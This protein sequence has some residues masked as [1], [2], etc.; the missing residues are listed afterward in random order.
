MNN[1]SARPEIQSILVYVGGDL[2]GDALMKLPF[3][4]ALRSSFPD[5]Q[6]TWCAGKHKSAFAKE[7]KTIVTGLIDEVIE[8]AGFDNARQFLWRRP[9]DGR[10][11]DLVIDTQRGVAVSF[12]V[13]RIRHK[14]FVSGAAKFLLSDRKPEPGYQRPAS[15]V[16]QMT[17]L[18]ALAGG[19]T[20]T[21]NVPLSLPES[22]IVKAAE[23]LPDG[24]T[25][26][27]IAPGAGGRQKC[28][29]LDRFIALAL[30]QIEKGRVP[31]FVLGPGEAEW[32]PNLIT[33]VP[34]ALFPTVGSNG[35]PQP[36]VSYS[37]AI[38]RRLKAAIANDAGVGHILAAADTPLVSLFGPTPAAKFAPASSRLT[39][40]EAQRFGGDEMTAIPVEAV[41]EATDRL[42]EI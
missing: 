2:I 20:D 1:P 42:L 14:I 18:L 26:I 11:F 29:P 8:E 33:A 36:S 9:I 16:Q 15:M 40:I 30:S 37:I 35:R 6:I 25:Y 28:W 17:D 12:I 3:V 39:V 31:V 19:Q 10:P 4:R 23:I 24:P 7:L 5:A 22:D 27:G 13:R 41:I 32:T 21:A 38:G 34:G